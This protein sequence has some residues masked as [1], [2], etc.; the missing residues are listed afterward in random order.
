MT[1]PSIQKNSYTSCKK[2][3]SCCKD[4]A[5]DKGNSGYMEVS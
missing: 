1:K 4:F 3:S 2:V 5:A